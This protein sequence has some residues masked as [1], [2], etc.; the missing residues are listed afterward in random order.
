MRLRRNA[1]VPLVA[2][3]LVLL[4]LAGLAFTSAMRRPPPA[5]GP[6]L[7]G[8]LPISAQT[9]RPARISF[10]DG[11]P[12]RLSLPDGTQETVRSLLNIGTAM[13]YGDWVWD[14]TG[15]PDGP[16]WVRVDLAR[17][18]LSVFRA[19]HEIGTAVILYGAPGNPTPSGTFPILAK[20]RVHRSSIYDADMPYMQ[21][22]TGD[23]V[24][25]HATDV[26]AGFASR[27]CI[28]LPSAFAKKL[29]AVTRIGDRVA[30]L[31]EQA[32]P[33]KKQG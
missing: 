1:V 9:E 27:G 16:V 28:G 14:T 18:M 13:H 29:F 17:Q 12:S 24:A 22:L 2:G 21:R 8:V 7:D 23:G 20:A 19:G 25:I 6:L 31:P 10:P 33:P 3:S 5:E 4:L 32:G 30:I 15:V 11:K 26:M